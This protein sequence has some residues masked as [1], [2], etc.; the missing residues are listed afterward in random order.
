MRLGVGICA[1]ICAALTLSSA[2]EAL[3]RTQALVV[4]VSGYPQLDQRLRLTGPRNDSRAVANALA[5]FGVPTDDI[6]VLA[7]GVSGLDEGISVEGPATRA[8]ILGAFD[9]LA[10]GAQPG[11]LVVFY[12]SGHGTQAADQDGD[13]LGG[14]DEIFLPYDAGKAEDGT[15]LAAIVDDELNERVEAILAKGADFFGI[16]DACTSA[17]GF[18]DIGDAAV[19]VRRVAPEIVGLDPGTGEAGKGF[20]RLRAHDD[21]SGRGRAAFFYAAQEGEAALETPAKNGAP[22]ESYGIF[23]FNLLKR[24]AENP[25]M[26]YRRVH[27]AVVSDI[28]RSSLMA[29][30]TPDLEGTLLDEPMLRLGSGQ[31]AR[32]WPIYNGDLS[33]GLLDGLGEGAVLA[34]YDDPAAPDDAA[35][36]RGVLETAGATRSVV[37]RIAPECA[38]AAA[39]ACGALPDDATWKKGRW[40]RLVEPGVDFSLTLS[41]PVRVD[42][43]DGR[44]YGPAIAALTQALEQ[45]AVKARVSTRSHGYDMAVGLVDGKLAFAPA[46]GLID[47][48]GPGTSPRLTLPLEPGDARTAVADALGRMARALAVQRL[49]DRL[50]PGSLGLETQVLVRRVKQADA[51]SD[52]CPELDD[53]AYAPAEPAGAETRFRACDVLAVSLK[54]SGRRAVD[55]TVLMV[56][57]DFSIVPVWP[58]EGEINRMRIGETRTAEV[59]QMQPDGKAGESRLVFIAVPGIN[60]AHVIFDALEQEGVRATPDDAP[61]IADA[62]ELLARALS[63]S[64][65]RAASMPAGLAEDMAVEVVPFRFE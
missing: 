27:Q 30:Q 3:A 60:R 53:E 18:R 17:T 52:V 50:A 51:A 48:D 11:D 2:P 59:L 20:S 34:L 63:G 23:T 65:T 21:A 57:N 64:G 54:N 33:A 41:E 46:A 26:S 37:T 24:L 4:G 8:A 10:A 29:T 47:S 58:T 1:A 9:R 7:D 43:G 42:P 55:V 14:A 6:T 35:L 36:A 56:G 49:G 12:F 38:G 16:I 44:D 39:E 22:D 61:A 15:S 19:K 32:Q 40:A 25:G 62:K 45:P 28:K 31:T 5:R 13:E